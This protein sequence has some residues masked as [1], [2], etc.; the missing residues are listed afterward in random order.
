MM[1][2]KIFI[3]ILEI[4]LCTLNGISQNQDNPIERNGFVIGFSLGSGLIHI[5]DSNTDAPFEVSN[6]VF[7]F[8]NL[9]VGWMLNSKTAILASYQ[10]AMYEKNGKDRSF[11]AILPS[12]QYWASNRWWLNMGLG[13]A[14]D[15]PAFYEKDIEN[16]DWNFGG[17]LSVGTGIE[18][19]Q[20]R[21]YALDLSSSL[22]LG[23]VK[24]N[25]GENGQR[26]GV[27][28]SITLGFNWY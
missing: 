8:P 28:F 12:L 27:V 14:M 10:G 20:T 7:S 5:S 13:L 17:A 18:L 21:N 4:L 3:I 9:K 26:G 1:D 22:L 19:K 24:T 6:G 25:E 16:E 11:D 2:L 15:T 23:G